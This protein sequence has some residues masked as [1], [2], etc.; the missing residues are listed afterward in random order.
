MSI[1]LHFL[2][3]HRDYFN[4]NYGDISEERARDSTMSFVRC[5]NVI[6]VTGIHIAWLTIAGVFKTVLCYSAIFNI[7]IE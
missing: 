7:K 3:K 5:R 2:Y 1:T 4:A 6:K